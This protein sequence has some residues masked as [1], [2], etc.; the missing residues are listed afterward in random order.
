MAESFDKTAWR[1]AIAKSD[2]YIK[3]YPELKSLRKQWEVDPENEHSKASKREARAF[4]EDALASNEVALADHG[5]NLDAERK[6]IDTIIVH[7]TSSKPGY[8]LSYMNAVQLLNI[9]VPYFNNPSESIPGEA[10]LKG[11]SLWSNHVRTGRPVF[12][13]YHWLM[14]MDGSFERLLNDDELGWHAANWDI[15][16]RSIAICLDN[17]YNQRDPTLEILQKLAEF[18]REH[19]PKISSERI[20]GHSEVSHHPTTCPGKNFVNDWKQELLRYYSS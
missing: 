20:F 2:W 6:P 5:P 9:Y 8:R 17:D 13:A 10:N 16:C 12:Y 14:R 1:T 18:I 11:S 4:F 19:Y 15:N 7:H 3:L